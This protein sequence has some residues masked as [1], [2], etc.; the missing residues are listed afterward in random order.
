MDLWLQSVCGPL[1]RTNLTSLSSKL[2]CA[3][4]W[5]WRQ[6]SV[7]NCLVCTYCSNA[8]CILSSLW[9]HS[10]HVPRSS[11]I[12][13]PTRHNKRKLLSVHATKTSSTIISPWSYTTSPIVGQ[14]PNSN[15]QEHQQCVVPT[16]IKMTEPS[17]VMSCLN[18]LPKNPPLHSL[19]R[20]G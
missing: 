4:S 3:I 20:V 17:I 9:M 18:F 14:S 8:W 13:G 2:L 10:L 15:F 12:V 16:Y 6:V 5:S 11:T 1:S 19:V 7:Q